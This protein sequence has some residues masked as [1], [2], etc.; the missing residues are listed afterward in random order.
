MKSESSSF[1]Y[2]GIFPAFMCKVA[3]ADPISYVNLTGIVAIPVIFGPKENQFGSKLAILPITFLLS[4]SFVSSCCDIVRFQFPPLS[5][6]S[7]A[8]FGAQRRRLLMCRFIYF[9]DL[10]LDGK[11]CGGS[12]R[13]AE[14]AAEPQC[15]VPHYCFLM[16]KSDGLQQVSH[17]ALHCLAVGGVLILD[18]TLSFSEEP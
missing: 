10:L 11:D 13:G 17:L 7:P 3:E 8:V 14:G 12:C 9:T 1:V 5:L 15:S 4:L 18:D 6:L 16:R 2:T